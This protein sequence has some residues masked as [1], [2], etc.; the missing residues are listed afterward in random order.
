MMMLL[1]DDSG[2]GD[3]DIFMYMMLSGG[4]GGTGTANGVVKGVHTVDP[5]MM[6]LL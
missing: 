1:D 6:M 3:N 2:S 5:L 4:M